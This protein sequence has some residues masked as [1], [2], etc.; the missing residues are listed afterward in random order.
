MI[1]ADQAEAFPD[2]LMY[3]AASLTNKFYEAL[4]QTWPHAAYSLLV[5]LEGRNFKI[6]AFQRSYK[7]DTSV[8]ARYMKFGTDFSSID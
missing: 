2:G 8:H 6:S 1:T 7:A 4:A 3:K 5:V